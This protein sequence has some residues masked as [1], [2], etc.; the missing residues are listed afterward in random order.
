MRDVQAHLRLAAF[1]RSHMTLR[2]VPRTMLSLD[3]LWF[4]GLRQ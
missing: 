1:T 4:R 2:R 3:E